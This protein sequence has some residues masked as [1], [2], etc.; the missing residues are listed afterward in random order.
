ML[1]PGDARGA[2]DRYGFRVP[3]IVVSPWAKA[4]YVSN[5]VQDHTSMLAFMERK[6]NLPAM[7]FRD[8]NAAPMTDYFDLKHAAFATPPPLKRAPGLGQG[9]RECSAAGLSPPMPTSPTTASD[10]S[11]FLARAR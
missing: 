2:Y 5:V 10:V 11:R 3:M 9:L 6:W 1:A 4:G 7:T 8:A